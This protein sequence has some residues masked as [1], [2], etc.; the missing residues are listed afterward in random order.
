MSVKTIYKCDKCGAEQG[1]TNQFW[2]VGL[3]AEHHPSFSPAPNFVPRKY[4]D[5]CR[6]CL[7]SLGIHAM[8]KDEPLSF[9]EPTLEDVIREIIHNELDNQRP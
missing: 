8:K 3:T 6:P 1:N 5:V 4:M 7:E 9:P 2:R